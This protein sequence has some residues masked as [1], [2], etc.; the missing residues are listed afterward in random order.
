VLA[1]VRR[2]ALLQVQPG[3]D[4][5]GDWVG[6]LGRRGYRRPRGRMRPTG[7][8]RLRAFERQGLQ[9]RTPSS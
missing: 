5:A 4:S 2:G 3:A 1:Q 9:W 7:S 6:K 8:G